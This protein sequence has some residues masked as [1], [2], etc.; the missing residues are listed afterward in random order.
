MWTNVIVVVLV[1]ICFFV[2]SIF[3]IFWV[4][5]ITISI[6]LSI[7]LIKG[8]Y[9]KWDNSPVLVSF[10]TSQTP[11]WKI[12]FPAITICPES[13]FKREIFNFTDVLIRIKRGEETTKEE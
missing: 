6:Y 1:L 10:A 7:V 13:K 5:I 3:R 8:T 2:S 12:P 9:V 11:I 4:I